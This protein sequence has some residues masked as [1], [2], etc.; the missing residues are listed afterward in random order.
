MEN[1]RSL[2]SELLDK[3]VYS[4]IVKVTLK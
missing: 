1:N 4:N 2:R 3:D